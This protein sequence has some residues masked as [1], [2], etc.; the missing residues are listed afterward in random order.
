MAAAIDL[1]DDFD[2]S[3]LRAMRETRERRAAGAAA[4][5]F[6][7]DLRW[8]S[9]QRG[10]R[11]GGVTLQIVRDWV[12][13]FNAHGPDGLIDRKAPGS[14][15]R[16]EGHSIAAALA[17]IIEDGPMPGRPWRGALADRRSVPMDVR[18]VSR[19]GR[20]ADDE[21][22]TAHHGLSQ[23]VGAAA[24]SC[25]GRGRDRGFQ[26][27][28]PAVWRRSRAKRAS[29]PTDIEIWFADEARIGQK[30]K[31]TRRWARRGTRPRR[32]RI[33]APPRPIFSARSARGRAKARPRPARCNTAAMN[34]HLAEIANAVAPGAHAVLLLDQAGWHMSDKLVV[35]PNITLLPLPRQ[36]PRTQS[37][38]ER[39]AVHAR[40]LAVEPRLHNPTTTS[41]IIAATPGTNSSIS[42]GA[43]C[44]S[45]CAIGHMGSDQEGWYK[46]K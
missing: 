3:A 22:R 1:R 32:R 31:I 5:G 46:P 23:A 17:R 20:R 9:A 2:A 28:F 7:G 10:G 33:S 25:P 6:G 40:Q 15:S 21:P 39:L 38:R 12:L 35:P 13:R 42:P 8:R 26:K 4:S 18:R 27:K 19:R 11:I 24:P 37:G 36:M 41:S 30:N 29:T 45:D 44:P 43:S 34:L 14:R 16:L